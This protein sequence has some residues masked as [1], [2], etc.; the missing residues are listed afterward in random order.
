MI[1]KVELAM[2]KVLALQDL[3]INGIASELNLQLKTVKKTTIKLSKKKL[4]KSNKI[5]K[6]RIFTITR[7][8]LYLVSRAP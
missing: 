6:I 5:K 1:S 4:I 2:L 8:G 3:T 7:L